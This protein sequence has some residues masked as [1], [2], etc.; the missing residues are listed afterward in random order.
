[1]EFADPAQ[2]LISVEALAMTSPIAF[3]F[4]LS[5][6]GC[7]SFY[8]YKVYGLDPGLKQ[9]L[10]DSLR[11]FILRTYDSLRERIKDKEQDPE[12]VSTQ[13]INEEIP[14]ALKIF[15]QFLLPQFA[16]EPYSQVPS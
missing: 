12:I 11:G 13:I 2:L 1:L 15:M 5:I 7:L 9:E 14:R 4:A 3:D 6:W 16:A 10:E 8:E